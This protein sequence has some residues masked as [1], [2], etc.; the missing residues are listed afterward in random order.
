MKITKE[1][2]AELAVEVDRTIADIAKEADMAEQTFYKKKPSDHFSP[3][4]SRRILSAVERIRC[5]KTH[6]EAG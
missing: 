3:K 4:S 2:V 1:Q 6:Q 5:G